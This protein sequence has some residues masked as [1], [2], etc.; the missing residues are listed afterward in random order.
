MSFDRMEDFEDDVSGLP[1][2]RVLRANRLLFCNFSVRVRSR[3]NSTV[4]RII[5]V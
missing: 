5:L 1:M 3:E 2:Y 4:N